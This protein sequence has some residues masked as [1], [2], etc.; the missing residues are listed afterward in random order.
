MQVPDTWTWYA[1]LGTLAHSLEPHKDIIT[2]AMLILCVADCSGEREG[3]QAIHYLVSVC[4][5]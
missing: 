5:A 2:P 3:H 1:V 4:L